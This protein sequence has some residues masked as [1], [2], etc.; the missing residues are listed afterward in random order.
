MM[1][2]CVIHIPCEGMRERIK[3]QLSSYLVTWSLFFLFHLLGCLDPWGH[4]LRVR[5]LVKSSN[6]DDMTF[7]AMFFFFYWRC[8]VIVSSK[9][10]YQ[11]YK[12]WIDWSSKLFITY[13]CTYSTHAFRVSL[14]HI[15]EGLCLILLDIHILHQCHVSGQVLVILVNI[16]WFA[17]TMVSNISRFDVYW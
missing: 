16:G 10:L 6:N 4:F 8:Y 1:S 5:W 14:S 12:A 15:L 7:I 17:N 11:F 3:W 13:M 9:G 2:V